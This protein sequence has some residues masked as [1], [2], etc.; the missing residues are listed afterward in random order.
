M[1]KIKVCIIALLLI[2]VILFISILT[3]K[4]YNKEKIESE[5]EE[6]GGE[7][8]ATL[9]KQQSPNIYFSVEKYLQ[10][11]FSQI[12]KEEY[13]KI[14][15]VLNEDYIKDNEI[16]IENVSNKITRISD[17]NNFD[18]D[19][20]Y[21]KEDENM[22]SNYV[23]GTLIYQKQRYT[24]YGLVEVNNSSYS[25]Y[26]ISENDYN[27]IIQET[28]LIKRKMIKPNV[29]NQFLTKNY[30]KEDVCY[31]YFKDYT[32]KLLNNPDIAYNLLDDEYKSIRFNNNE[33]IF[34]EYIKERKKQIEEAVMI[35]YSYIYEGYVVESIILK[36]NFNNT[37]I[38]KENAVLD[39]TIQLDNYT[40]KSEE[41][42]NEYSKLS[43][44]EKVSNNM[45]E[46][47][48][49][50][51]TKD[52]THLY[53]KLYEKFRNNY[54]P[55]ENM[56]KEYMEN[57]YYEYNVLGVSSI[58]Q[59]SEYIYTCNAVLKDGDSSVAETKKF[60]VLI[61]LTDNNDYVYSF[62]VQ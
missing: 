10:Q 39:Y 53:N 27:D 54:F 4:I 22:Y 57:N 9:K 49:M 31:E 15:Y 52:Y 62:T 44:N 32:N 35:S 24:W 1:N 59:E 13:E 38:I 51:N 34:K 20:M 25:I 28:K 29:Y 60:T 55:N 46:I 33:E 48:K 36:D 21:V 23:K 61:S 42:Y 41:Y 37:Y 8:I 40:I 7:I 19:E 43:D 5:L 11:Y 50:L 17:F 58:K 45:N 30:T 12:A 14:Y 47:I 18:V 56:F 6:E 26:P 2:C 16:T 3:I